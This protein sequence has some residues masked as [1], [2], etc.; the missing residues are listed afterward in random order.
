MP[1]QTITKYVAEIVT[2]PT[3]TKRLVISIENDGHIADEA[4]SK[5][6]GIRQ[7]KLA[8]RKPR[9]GRKWKSI[10]VEKMRSI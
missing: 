1:I 8:K 6:H 9:F 2:I 10:L 3:V 5:L 4:S 7:K